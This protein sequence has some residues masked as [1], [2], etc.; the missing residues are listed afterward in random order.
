MQ[1]V[2]YGSAFPVRATWLMMRWT[3]TMRTW[4]RLAM[5]GANSVMKL[6]MGAVARPAAL[7]LA[8]AL[9]FAVPEGGWR[10]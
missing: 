3:R 2:A 1:A 5:L 6:S 4:R 10:R 7:R 8:L 9:I